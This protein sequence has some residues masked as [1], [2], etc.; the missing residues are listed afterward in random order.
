VLGGI[1]DAEIE[2]EFEVVVS[3]PISVKGELQSAA[4]NNAILKFG[5]AVLEIMLARFTEKSPT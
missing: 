3:H 5:L 4:I 2:A 1:D